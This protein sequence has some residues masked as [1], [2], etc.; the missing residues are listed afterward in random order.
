MLIQE[1]MDVDQPMPEMPMLKTSTT[2]KMLLIITV[3]IAYFIGVFVSEA[4]KKPAENILDI[5]KAGSP[6]AKANN[7][8]LVIATSWAVKALRWKRTDKIGPPITIKAT[9]DGT[10]RKSENS[11]DRRHVERI[12][13]QSF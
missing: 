11:T 7:T 2:F 4:A 13:S 6:V 1:A 10:E 3:M 8:L 5:T 9:A 12:P